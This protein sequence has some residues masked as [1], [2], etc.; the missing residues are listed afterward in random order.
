LFVDDKLV[1]DNWTRQRRGDSF[2]GSGTREERGGLSLKAGQSPKIRVEYMN[3][4]GPADG[5]EDE[6]VM[7]SNPGVQLGGSE[8]EDPEM[9]M[10]QAV[11][12]AKEADVVVAVVGLNAEWETEGYDRYMLGLP[13]RTDELIEK[14]VAANPKTIVVVQSVSGCFALLLG[15]SAYISFRDRR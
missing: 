5:D 1:I 12:A 3:V 4:R 14:V 10:E 9:L 7:D 2:F 11:K 13:G 15:H 6:Q 8:I